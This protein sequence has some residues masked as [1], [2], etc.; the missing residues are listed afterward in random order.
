[1]REVAAQAG[2][3]HSDWDDKDYPRLQVLSLAD[4]LE[5]DIQPT[6]PPAVR[7]PYTRAQRIVEAP[8]QERLFD[9]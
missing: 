4:L 3:Y 2:V 5:R 9:S 1:M 7:D 8:G 6:L